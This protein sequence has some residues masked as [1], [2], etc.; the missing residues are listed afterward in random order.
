M[1][2]E[3]TIQISRARTMGERLL[4]ADALVFSR[5]QM[6]VFDENAIQEK[7]FQILAR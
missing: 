5:L 4:L 7:A 2:S 1:T 3:F 6:R